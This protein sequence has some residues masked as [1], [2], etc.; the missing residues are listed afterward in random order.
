[1]FLQLTLIAVNFIVPKMILTTFGSN[2]NGLISSLSQFL[3][4]ISLIEGGITGVIAA[5]FY[6]PLSE[7]NN[8]KI[9]AIVASAKNF[10]K[11]VGLILIAYTLII[12]IF[13]PLIFNTGFSYMYVFTLTLILSIKLI[14]QYLFSLTYRTLLNADKKIYIVSFTQILFNILEIFF[15]ILSVK[16]F[17]SVH[18]LKAITGILFIAQPIIYAKY[19]RKY[20]HIDS[21]VKPDKSLIKSRWDGLAVN[22]AAFIHNGT[23]IAVLTICTNLTTVSVYSIYALVTSGIKSIINSL[24]SSLNPII[25]QAYAKRN[26]KN[27]HQKLD[28]YEYITF[29]LVFFVFSVTAL[30]ITP[31]VMIYTQNITDTN[32]CQPLFGILLVLSEAI[33]LLKYPHLNLAYAANKFKDISIP[34]FIEAGLNLATSL[35]LVSSLGLIGVAI[36]TIVAMI[37][38]LAFHVFY[39]TKIIPNRPQKIFYSKLAVF[40]I[41]TAI[42][43][44]F[45]SLV[46]IVDYTIISWIWHGVVYSGIMGATFFLASLVFFK[47]ELRYIKSYMKFTHE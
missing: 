20:Y 46:P 44:L 1:M 10:Y 41:S 25:G 42:G 32:Y 9:S 21:S 8:K 14:I 3:S 39:T 5:T 47:P 11:K 4:Y 6:K 35:I 26:Y 38:R 33:Y 13:Y 22:V 7:H 43:I 23:D 24:V 45:C 29:M 17:P 16:I 34:S 36:G 19:V 12:A 18:L 2:T 37:Y 31:F 28:L 30:L 40:S 27:L 15:A